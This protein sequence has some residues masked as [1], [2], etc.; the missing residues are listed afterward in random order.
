MGKIAT[1]NGKFNYRRVMSD[2]YVRLP[3]CKHYHLGCHISRQIQY[4]EIKSQVLSKHPDS[5]VLY[6]GHLSINAL[7]DETW[8][9]IAYTLVGP[10][11]YLVFMC[12]FQNCLLHV[13][14]KR[15]KL[16]VT[17]DLSIYHDYRE[18]IP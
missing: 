6:S 8:D 12:Y 18:I 10:L 11:K 4:M 5:W 14:F 15:R 3:E 17:G 7:H 13:S 2:G 16:L 9:L 1:V